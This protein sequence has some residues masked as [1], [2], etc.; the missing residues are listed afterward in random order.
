MCN[1]VTTHHPEFLL[2]KG[3]HEGFEWEIT[4]NG[5]GYRCGYVRIPPGHPWHGRDYDSVEPYPAVHG[6]LTFAEADTDC[7]KGGEDNAWW[8]GFDCAHAGDAADPSLPGRDGKPLPSVVL[9]HFDD[10]VIRT[11]DYVEAECRSLAGQAL[12]AAS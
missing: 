10:D 6:G 12:A 3:V 4:N 9:H 2:A 8:L 5:I 1:P 11:T 7:G